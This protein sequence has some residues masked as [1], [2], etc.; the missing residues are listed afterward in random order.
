[1]SLLYFIL[2]GVLL[3]FLLKFG[4]LLLKALTSRQHDAHRIAGWFP[5][6]EIGTWILFSFW[7]AYLLF[8]GIS[9]YDHL[10]FFMA[11]LLVFGVS[12]YFFRDFFAGMI[13]KS[14]CQLREGQYIKTPNT[15]GVIILL[16]PRYLELENNQGERVKIPY[17]NLN[18]Q[19][20]TLP[21]QTE[22]TLSNHF[23][24]RIP[25]SVDPLQVKSVVH[26]GMMDLPWIVGMPPVIKLIKDQEDHLFLDIRYSLLKEEHALLVEKKVRQMIGSFLSK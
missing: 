6:F 24:V 16:G 12:W 14:E 17:S 4:A 5:L 21:A 23:L 10:V 26:Q 20:I 11:V 8:G 3:Y 1:M 2:S 22:K 19:W 18:K 13:M 7:G 9:Y 25:E 15:E